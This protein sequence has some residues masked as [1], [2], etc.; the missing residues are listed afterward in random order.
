MIATIKGLNYGHLARA[1]T[2]NGFVERV[3]LE[4]RTFLHPSGARLALPPLGNEEPLRG[5][6]YVAARAMLDD[7]GIL[8]RDAF[9]LSLAR[10][11][12]SA[13]VGG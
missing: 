12:T 3:T 8:P 4:G 11:Q 10:L 9:E 13:A 6:H 1:L 7:Y 2:E 5:Y